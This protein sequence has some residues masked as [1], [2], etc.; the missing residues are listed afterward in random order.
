MS[1]E[2]DKLKE[3]IAALEESRAQVSANLAVMAH[4]THLLSLWVHENGGDVAAITAAASKTP[5]ADAVR[6]HRE[7]LAKLDKGVNTDKPHDFFTG[8]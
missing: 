3:Q 2:I 4:N 6:F 7:T 1:S 8:N 5:S